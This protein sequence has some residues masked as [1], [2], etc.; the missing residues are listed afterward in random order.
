MDR[1][2]LLGQEKIHKLLIKFSIPTIIGMLVNALYNI[3][4]R[5][6]IGHGVGSLAIAGITVGFPAMIICMAF[7]ML[8]GFGGT[9]LISIRLG[10]QRQKDAEL[11]MGNGVTLLI[12]VPLLVSLIGLLFLKPLL[13]FL[14]ASPEVLPYAISYLRIILYG[15]VLMSVE[16]G[17]NNFI[18]A[19]GNPKIAMLT[20]LIGAITN[21]I[22][23]YI[24]IFIF[25]F[26][27]GKSL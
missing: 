4:D 14:G 22:L 1:A 9:A 23:D 12:I 24:F 7:A 18:K 8:I 19:E 16:L 6:F 11:I 15:N 17:M 25:N 10:Q 2:E 26:L 27:S 3:V 20:M 13:I 21:V 5:I